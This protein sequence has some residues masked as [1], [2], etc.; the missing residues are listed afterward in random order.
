MNEDKG[1]SESETKGASAGPLDANH[2][3]EQVN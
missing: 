3:T 1:Q 2:N